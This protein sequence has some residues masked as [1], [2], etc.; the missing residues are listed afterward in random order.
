M[1][2]INQG[3]LDPTSMYETDKVKLILMQEEL[4]V[5]ER[6]EEEEEEEEYRERLIKVSCRVNASLI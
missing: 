4:E 2:K 5:P 3:G 6:E 1:S